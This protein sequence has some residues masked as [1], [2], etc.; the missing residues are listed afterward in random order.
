VSVKGSQVRRRGNYRK[1]RQLQE[2]QLPKTTFSSV[3]KKGYTTSLEE[4]GR[5]KECWEGIFYV[6]KG[7]RH[8]GEGNDTE[9]T[10]PSS[11]IKGKE[12]HKNT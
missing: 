2:E 8:T 3:E 9:T 6:V 11:K 4:G 7:K 10:F 1:K 5:E 12:G